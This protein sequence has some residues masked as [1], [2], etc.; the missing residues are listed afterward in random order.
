MIRR[1][2]RSTLFPYTTLF[3][4]QWLVPFVVNRCF[5]WL[6][7]RAVALRALCRPTSSS[8]LVLATDRSQVT[9]KQRTPRSA[10]IDSW[11]DDYPQYPLEVLNL[12][13]DVFRVAGH[14]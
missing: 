8:W 2:P 12:A 5:G 13:A 11:S 4:S 10:S 3:R 9:L 7:N 6:G 1:P 14:M